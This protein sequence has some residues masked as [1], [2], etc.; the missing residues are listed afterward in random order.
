MDELRRL[1]LIGCLV[2]IGLV[3]LLCLGSSL[4]TQPPSFDQRSRS[5]LNDAFV[6]QQLAARDIDMDT[7]RDEISQT[8]PEDPPGMA[9][10][11]MAL[12]N[13][14]LLLA[15]VLTALPL[16]VGDRI[17]GSLQGVVSIV[18]GLLGVIGGIALAMIAFSAL[19]LMV[20]LFLAAPFGTLA[21]LAIYGSFAKGAAAAVLGL[22]LVLQ[23]LAAALL[24]IAQQ[25]FLLSKGLM[26]LFLTT[27]LLTLLTS[28]LH[29]F[30]PG[31]LVSITDALAALVIAIVGIVWSLV[32]LVGGVVGAVRVLQLGRQG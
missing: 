2:A 27:M 9:I 13:G 19:M 5:A 30:V 1:P 24:I 32:F 10:P 15:L 11:N 22:V 26:L 16:L 21:Y 23:V 8:R 6:R 3:V 17:T 28:I 20:S 7:A 25:R 12:V 18:G 4:V 14:L 29:S 31:I